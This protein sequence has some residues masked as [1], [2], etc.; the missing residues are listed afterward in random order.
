MT[1]RIRPH[2]YFSMSTST[3]QP[4]EAIEKTRQANLGNTYCLGIWKHVI[5]AVIFSK[6]GK[7]KPQIQVQKGGSIGPDAN[8]QVAL[9][10]Q[11]TRDLHFDGVEPI[12]MADENA[13]R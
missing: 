13:A 8:C 4:Q 3:K 2:R 12:M 10:D 5:P 6:S 9:S 1:V 11:L 7:P